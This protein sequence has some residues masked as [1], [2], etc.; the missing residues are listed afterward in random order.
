VGIADKMKQLDVMKNPMVAS[1]IKQ[2]HLV[3]V[4]IKKDIG[5]RVRVF[6]SHVHGVIKMVVLG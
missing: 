4:A 3:R 2:K 1:A 5:Q 6:D